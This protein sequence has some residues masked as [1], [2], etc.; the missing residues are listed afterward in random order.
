[1]AS[2]PPTALLPVPLA[3]FQQPGLWDVVFYHVSTCFLSSAAVPLPPNALED[4]SGQWQWLLGHDS[5]SRM[6]SGLSLGRLS[7]TVS[8]QGGSPPVRR[9]LLDTFE[10][11][12]VIAPPHGGSPPAR[13]TA[14]ADGVI[15][16]QRPATEHQRQLRQASRGRQLRER[17]GDFR[18]GFGEELDVTDHNVGDMSVVCRYCHALRFPAEPTERLN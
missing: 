1:M 9:R 16:A 8:P 17:F 15:M 2:P 13:R 14:N 11:D 4:P 12:A 18:K 7:S 3:N 10:A 6:L 5:P